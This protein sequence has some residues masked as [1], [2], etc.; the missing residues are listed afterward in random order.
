[1]LATMTTAL[2]IIISKMNQSQW[3][4]TICSSNKYDDKTVLSR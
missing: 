2:F 1:M 3:K 4:K